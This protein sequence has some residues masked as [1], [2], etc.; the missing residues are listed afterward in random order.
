M[1]QYFLDHLW[2]CLAKIYF[3]KQFIKKI[4]NFL[5]NINQQKVRPKSKL[6]LQHFRR[7]LRKSVTFFGRANR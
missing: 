3:A 5:Q 7:F 6:F 1:V 2:K 4:L